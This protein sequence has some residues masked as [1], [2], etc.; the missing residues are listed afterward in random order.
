MF[1]SILVPLDGS[2]SAEHALQLATWLARRTGASLRLLHVRPPL[3]GGWESE[4]EAPEQ[5]AKVRAHLNEYLG[6]QARRVS[7]Q[8]T[9]PAAYNIVEGRVVANIIDKA[10]LANADLIV[11]TPH[12]HG[13]PSAA[14]LGSVAEGVVRQS[15]IPVLVARP[16]AEPREPAIEHILVPL[17]G[18]PASEEALEPAL[19]M[20]RATRATI[21]LLSVVRLP[22]RFGEGP[23]A[24]TAGEDDA[25]EGYRKAETYV[26]DVAA[27]L[28]R[29][30][31]A[32]R[33]L[34]RVGMHPAAIILDV[35]AAIGAD[36]I[37]MATHGRSR[38]QRMTVGSVSD[39]VLRASPTPVLLVQPSEISDIGAIADSGEERS[40]LD[41]TV[42]VGR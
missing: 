3:D 14:W 12:G 19:R 9:R 2:A 29:E 11:L 31:V 34:V 37:A 33:P 38:L 36:L 17:D 1:R 10:K 39:K 20:A 8:L 25:A 16:P 6:I 21:T 24:R 41:R 35:A 28:A 26:M 32:V 13:G 4:D 30:G 42:T 22:Q 27:R 23:V 7:E 40:G 15:P 18:S 5:E